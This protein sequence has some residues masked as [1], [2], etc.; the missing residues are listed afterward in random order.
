MATLIAAPPLVFFRFFQQV[1]ISSIA[2]TGI[3]G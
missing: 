3:R 2:R 1:F